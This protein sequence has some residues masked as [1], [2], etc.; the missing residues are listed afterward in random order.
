MVNP[1][2][3]ISI[4]FTVDE[5]LSKPELARRPESTKT[6]P[7]PETFDFNGVKIKTD[8]IKR[9]YEP[10]YKDVPN[11]VVDERKIYGPVKPGISIGNFK[12]EA[13]GTFGCIVYDNKSGSLIF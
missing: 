2:N 5:K 11:L 1:Q 12:T 8:V 6:T 4:Q 9:K 7:I 13:A 3:E 10:C